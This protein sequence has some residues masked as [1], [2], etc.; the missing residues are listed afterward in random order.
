MAVGLGQY[1][2]HLQVYLL[3]SLPSNNSVSDICCVKTQT[4]HDFQHDVW[5]CHF[6]YAA[7]LGDFGVLAEAFTLIVV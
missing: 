1:Y 3:S 7:C 4:V 6:D 5:L 2:D